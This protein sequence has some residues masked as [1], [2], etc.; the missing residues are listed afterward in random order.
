M[1][2]N[3]HHDFVEV[4]DGDDETSR[5]IGRY[6]GHELPPILA[7]NSNQMFIRFVSDGMNER[8]G[9]SAE[10]FQEIN[11][12]ASHDHRCEQSCINTLGGYACMCRLGYKLRNDNKTCEATCGG[13][14]SETNGIIESPSF[15]NS[16]PA[17][18]ACIWEIKAVNASQRIMLNFT[19]FELEGNLKLHEECSYDNVTIFSENLDGTSIQQGRYCSERLPFTI[20]SKTPV[21]RIEFRS[22]KSV[23]K[24]GFF[25]KFS[26]ITDAC[27]IKNGGCQHSCRNT[28]DSYE[29]YCKTGFTLHANG[30]DCIPG[31]CRH[32]ITDATGVI[33]SD[34]YPKN[35]TKNTDCIWHFKAIHGHRRYLV[36][37]KFDIEYDYDCQNDN[38][39]VYIA[40]D[41]IIKRLYVTSETYTLGTYCGTQLP[42][43]IFSPSDSDFFMAFHTDNSIQRQGFVVKHSTICGGDFYATR[44]TKYIYSHVKYG[45][46]VYDDNTSCDWIIKAKHP[47]KRVHLHFHQF[48]LEDEP[49]CL[50]DFIEIF[51][52]QDNEWRKRG[53]FCGST[54]PKEISTTK[55]L[56][57][58][59]RTND[60]GQAK[61]FSFSYTIHQDHFFQ[62]SEKTEIKRIGKEIPVF[63]KPL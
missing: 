5:L 39:S 26:I 6:C 7:S 15:P 48:D 40:V 23:Q 57:I 25:A 46:A 58:K 22:D 11:E 20:R 27:A 31:T 44:N 63:V 32:D 10:I 33:K 14:I 12:C 21:M 29:C 19:H 49:N 16:Y 51:E 61:G 50:T 55:Q 1:I 3:C 13:E 42:D 4:R 54:S 36:F 60:E 8:R 38:V 28:F 37:E 56:L 41:R 53:R 35:Y 24:S 45:Q 9:F 62:K 17:N 52:E 59:F 2:L 18:T 34:N 47:G 30:R 43:P